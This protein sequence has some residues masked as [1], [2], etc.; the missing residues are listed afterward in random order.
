MEQLYHLYQLG[1]FTRD[2][3][4]SPSVFVLEACFR[5]PSILLWL[6]V[7]NLSSVLLPVL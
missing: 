1:R 2:G 5:L 3:K 4:T 7:Y 6:L